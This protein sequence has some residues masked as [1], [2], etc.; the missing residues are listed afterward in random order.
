MNRQLKSVDSEGSKEK[1]ITESEVR[2]ITGRKP[3]V[4]QTIT[5]GR[6]GISSGK[7]KARVLGRILDEETGEPM[8]FVAV[9]I[10]EMKTG[11]VNRCK[12]FFQPRP[13]TGE[14]Q[15]IC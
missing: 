3:G 4:T 6:A 10:A 7:S 13:H 15:C 5:I 12:R 1:A 2:Y 11:A 9:Y 8:S 14:I